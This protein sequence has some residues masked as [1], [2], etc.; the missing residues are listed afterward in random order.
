MAARIL[1]HEGRSRSGVA[2]ELGCGAAAIPATCAAFCGFEAYAT[3]V[4]EMVSASSKALA[5]HLRN[6]GFSGTVQR[7]LGPRQQ[8]FAAFMDGRTS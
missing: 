4:P 7:L 2:I 5:D 1:K 8:A 3:D 6:G